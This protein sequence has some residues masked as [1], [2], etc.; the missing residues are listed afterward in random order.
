MWEGPESAYAD[1]MNRTG[2][3][4]LATL[5]AG[6]PLAGAACGGGDDEAG[7]TLPPIA[8]TTST[9]ISLTTT[10]II[11]T[12]YEIQSGD[13]LGNIARTFGVSLEEL[14]TINS[15]PNADDIEAGQRLL[16]PPSTVLVTIPPPST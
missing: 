10:T 9:T 7:T 4:G 13:T 3:V 5:L 14:M 15:I 11:Q 2:L 16:I 8:T 6:I 12:Y 1:H